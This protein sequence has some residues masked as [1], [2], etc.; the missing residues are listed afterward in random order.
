MAPLN[1]P[2]IAKVYEALSAV[3]DG[4]VKLTGAASAQVVSSGHD[5][6]YTVKWSPEG[7]EITSD[8]NAT[9][10]Q[11]Y[12]GYPIIAV[13][14]LTGRLRHD[15]AV[16]RWLAGV[17]WHALNKQYKR[18]YD[19]AVNHVLEGLRQ[20]GIDPDVVRGEAVRIHGALA[21]MRLERLT[22]KPRK[23][24]EQTLS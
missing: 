20:R 2:P 9:R 23:S 14:L 5:K 7:G 18:D 22:T 21:R 10:W 8:D 24:G 3:G 6:T 16:A 19:A 13:L 4:R 12:L 17:P 15:P 1:Q 11:G